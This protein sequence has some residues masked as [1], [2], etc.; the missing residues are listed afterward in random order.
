M[1]DLRKGDCLEIMRG[2]PD[3][4]IDLIVTDPPYELDMSHKGSGVYAD[5]KHREEVV[6][7]SSG[8]AEEI[9]DEMV[10]VMK[11]I[12]IYLWC[13]R[14]QMPKLY[15][16]FVGKHKCKWNLLTWHKDNPVPA[17]GQKYLNDTEYIMYFKQG[18]GK[19]VRHIRNQVYLPG[20]ALEYCG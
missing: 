16:Y 3:K 18:G 11:R 15:N 12:N 10:R 4:C 19:I 14:E 9:L 17:C 20:Y 6:G 8:F 5:K 7:I 1:I 2:M 13:S